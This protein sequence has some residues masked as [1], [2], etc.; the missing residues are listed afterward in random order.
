[1]VRKAA[2][3]ETAKATRQPKFMSLRMVD[4]LMSLPLRTKVR[5]GNAFSRSAGAMG[6]L[7]V[8]FQCRLEPQFSERSVLYAVPG[9]A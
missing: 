7:S 6:S 9:S 8:V 5:S 4:V 1:M 3:P 2:G